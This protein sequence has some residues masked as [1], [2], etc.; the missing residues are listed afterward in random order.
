MT[1]Q[2]GLDLNLAKI[3]V[4]VIEYKSFSGAARMLRLPKSTVSRSVSQL[5]K[6]LGIQLI[7]RT[8]RQF[9]MTHQGEKFYHDCRH[10]LSD[11]EVKVNQLLESKKGA[12]GTIRVT[13]PLDL[14]VAVLNPFIIEFT[15]AYPGVEIEVDY[16]DEVINL[17]REGIDLALRIGTPKDS[18]LKMKKIGESG[19]SIVA[20]HDYWQRRG[21]PQKPADLDKL[22]YMHFSR[23][24]RA[25]KFSNGKD[26]F[27]VKNDPRIAINNLESLKN[28]VMA[29]QG[30]GVIPDFFVKAE[31]QQGK[32]AAVL[33][34]YKTPAVPIYWA[35]PEHKEN[36]PAIK[37]FREFVTPKI[38]SVL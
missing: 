4:K 36:A 26:S 35:M 13:A 30:F 28:I 21:Y 20:T 38:R 27:D 34:S 37:N 8:T 18:R 1:E 7:L 6:D 24:G 2:L 17:V 32:L 16:S 33:E 15:Q 31:I 3:Y 29:S 25:I 23:L 12:Q 11:F 9:S 10:L 22:T 19:F 14:G 5:E